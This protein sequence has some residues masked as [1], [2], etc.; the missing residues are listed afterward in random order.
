MSELHRVV[1]GGLG[2]TVIAALVT[3]RGSVLPLGNTSREPQSGQ[4]PERLRKSWG[5]AGWSN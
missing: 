2:W 5:D 4:D 3:E 1:E